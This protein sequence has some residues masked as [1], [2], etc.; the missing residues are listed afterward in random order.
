MNA[1]PYSHPVNHLNTQSSSHNM[2][3]AGNSHSTYNIALHHLNEDEP[4]TSI[5][6]DV[7][8]SIVNF[9]I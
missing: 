9:R 8:K 5:D 6:S 3:T 7:L 2:N 1:N 4:I